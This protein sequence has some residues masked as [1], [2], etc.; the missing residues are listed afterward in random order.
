[1]ERKAA[2]SSAESKF[3]P[4]RFQKVQKDTVKTLQEQGVLESLQVADYIG[5]HIFS[6]FVDRVTENFVL[7][8]R[9]QFA[10]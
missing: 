2:D 4:K 3:R 6:K 8:N 1:M 5:K 9:K 10:A 7:E